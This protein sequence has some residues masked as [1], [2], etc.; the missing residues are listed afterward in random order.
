MAVLPSMIYHK[1]VI[2][3]YGEKLF[4]IGKKR[5][6]ETPIEEFMGIGR[7]SFEYIIKGFK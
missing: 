6:L 4:E 2:K 7:E 1:D 3:E 5:I